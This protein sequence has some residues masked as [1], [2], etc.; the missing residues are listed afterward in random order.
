VKIN[1]AFRALKEIAKTETSLVL[2]ETIISNLNSIAL[3]VSRESI[4]DDLS[5]MIRD[6]ITVIRE[7]LGWD[8]NPT[9]S[10]QDT[11]LRPLIIS[12]SL[13]NGND[14]DILKAQTMYWSNTDIPVELRA[15]VYYAVVRQGG[16][17]AYTSMVQRYLAAL[18]GGSDFER[19]RCMYALAQATKPSLLKRTL[20]FAL[21]DKLRSQDAGA[22]IRAVARNP[23]GVDLAWDFVSN[24][25]KAILAKIGDRMFQSYIVVGTTGLF[26]TDQR[27][28]QVNQL[29][30][31]VAPGMALPQ[32]LDM[33][34]ANKFWLD[35]NYNDLSEYL[36]SEYPVQ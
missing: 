8:R 19:Q 29:F 28:D 1:L 20:E 24:N 16:E 17:K 33:I 14:E 7:R 6:S 27:Y 12:A 10:E 13:S 34:K 9:E 30:S 32:A 2:W 25:Y 26:A 21:T 22:L 35:K 3:K 5:R 31:V 18:N 23:Y 36:K 11:Q 4:A 15:A